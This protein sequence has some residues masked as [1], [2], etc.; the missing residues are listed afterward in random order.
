[1]CNHYLLYHHQ[2]TLAIKKDLIEIGFCSTA[3][4]GLP[5]WYPISVSSTHTLVEI[6]K[7]SLETNAS[8]W[9]LKIGTVINVSLA[10]EMPLRP[11]RV[12]MGKKCMSDSPE[13]RPLPGRTKWIWRY[14]L[15]LQFLERYHHSQQIGNKWTIFNQ[16]KPYSRDQART[17]LRHILQCTMEAVFSWTT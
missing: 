3:D 13:S 9:L 14:K 16:T 10:S 15:H 17:C 6:E 11:Q 5:D 8:Y 1:M 7:R 4:Y 12:E 2:F